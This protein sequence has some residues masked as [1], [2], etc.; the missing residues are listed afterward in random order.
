MTGVVQVGG[1]RTAAL[2]VASRLR[3]RPTAAL[4]AAARSRLWVAAAAA[5]AANLRR[6]LGEMLV[7]AAGETLAPGGAW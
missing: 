7:S 2:A 6:R 4:A 5:D 1:R 3:Q